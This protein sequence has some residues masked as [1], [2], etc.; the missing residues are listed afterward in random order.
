[1]AQATL[2]RYNTLF[3]Q[4]W[5]SAQH[6]DE[7]QSQA[8]S[9]QASVKAAQARADALID[10]ARITDEGQILEVVA[11]LDAEIIAKVPNEGELVPAGYAIF[12]LMTP[13]NMW[14]SL[15]VREDQ[16]NDLKIG[17]TIRAT[18]PALNKTVDF[19]VYYIAVQGDFATWRAT[20]QSSG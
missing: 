18:I 5:I 4:G 11:P 8:L 2:R 17:Q 3:K 20:R 14:L 1:L 19:K 15:N 6:H 10:G 7:A 13:S 12:T 9:A 16:F